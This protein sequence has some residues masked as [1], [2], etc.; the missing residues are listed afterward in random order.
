MKPD[1]AIEWLEVMLRN[2]TNG[3]MYHDVHRD[4][5]AEAL[6]VGIDAIKILT[7]T[8]QD[9]IIRCKDCEYADESDCSADRK[10][11]DMIMRYVKND[12][13]CADGKRDE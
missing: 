9:D 1:V 13:F 4:A 7:A 8:A 5:K 10:W 11:C 3:T 12:W 2:A 6:Q